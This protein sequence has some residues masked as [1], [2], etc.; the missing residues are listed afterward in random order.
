M[1]RPSKFSFLILNQLCACSREGEG[2]SFFPK[3]AAPCIRT[4]QEIQ[5]CLRISGILYWTQKALEIAKNRHDINEKMEPHLIL[6]YI[7]KII[8]VGS[9]NVNFG[10]K[11]LKLLPQSW[12]FF[13]PYSPIYDDIL[14]YYKNSSICRGWRNMVTCSYLI[15]TG[16][17]EIQCFFQS[18]KF[19]RSTV[20][21]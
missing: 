12:N 3:L 10:F 5:I 13:Y 21:E 16:T 7:L 8:T 20:V 9:K 14:M 15:K 4:R 2:L 1:N 18:K 6:F 19:R 11:T 17:Y